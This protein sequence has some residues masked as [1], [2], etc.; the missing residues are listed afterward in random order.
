[1]RIKSKNVFIFAKA[2]PFVKLDENRKPVI[3]GALTRHNNDFR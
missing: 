2:F 1:M 3:V